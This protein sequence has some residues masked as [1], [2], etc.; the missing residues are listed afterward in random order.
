MWY[1]QL[2]NF[3][4]F[5]GKDCIVF[6]SSFYGPLSVIS[7]SKTDMDRIKKTFRWELW[8]ISLAI[9]SFY[10]K[11]HISLYFLSGLKFGMFH[12]KMLNLTV[13]AQVSFAKYKLAIG[14][15]WIT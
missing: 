13:Y 12:Y 7:R 10:V 4:R 14:R 1:A 11:M 3:R 5:L 8:P 9:K 2:S 6:I 15:S